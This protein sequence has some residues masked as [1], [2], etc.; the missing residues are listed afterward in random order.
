M[1]FKLTAEEME[2]YNQTSIK[3]MKRLRDDIRKEVIEEE[4]ASSERINRLMIAIV[5]N[6]L[7]IVALALVIMRSGILMR[8][9][10][11]CTMGIALVAI[12]SSMYLSYKWLGYGEDDEEYEVIEGE[13]VE[14]VEEVEEEAVRKEGV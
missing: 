8:L 6:S 2:I 12:A 11:F 7:T 1:D 14:E 5:I 4:G 13:V 9:G 3:Y 10:L